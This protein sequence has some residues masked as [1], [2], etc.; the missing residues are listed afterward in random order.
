VYP[1]HLLNHAL[2]VNNDEPAKSVVVTESEV[3]EG[4][5]TS[6]HS[7][8]RLCVQVR[9]MSEWRAED[10]VAFNHRSQVGYVLCPLIRGEILFGRYA[11][12]ARCLI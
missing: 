11:P 3:C 8:V 12:T 7:P 1:T 9:K 2:N 6:Y 5:F 4:S 10:G